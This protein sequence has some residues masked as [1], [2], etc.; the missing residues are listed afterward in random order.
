MSDEMPDEPQHN[1]RWEDMERAAQ[2]AA[3]Q[4]VAPFRLLLDQTVAD[5]RELKGTVYGNP[6]SRRLGMVDRLD[7][8]EGQITQ[9]G[10]RFDE[11]FDV[12]DKKLE[13]QIDEGKARGNQIAG[14]RKALYILAAAIMFVGGLPALATFLKAL[15]LT[16]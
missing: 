8:I 5:V 6:S 11:R 9:L 13:D 10:K 14:A 16:P 7:L 4:E 3:R 2:V 1:R 12:F 15:G